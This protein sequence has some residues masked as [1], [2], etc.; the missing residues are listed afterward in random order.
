[1]TPILQPTFGVMVYQEQVMK[2]AQE[3]AG[4]SLGKADLLRRAMGK[5]IKKEMDDQRA[6]FLE[7]AEQKAIDADTAVVIFDQ[8][9]KFAGYGFN[10]SH[11]APY[12]LVT[13]QTAYMKAN[14]PAEFM[15]A[16][17]TYDMLNTDKMYDYCQELKRMGIP[18]LLP[19][20]NKSMP[21]FGVEEDPKTGTLV[22]RYGLAALKNVGVQA[23]EEIV[24]ER[25]HQGP[26][27]DLSDLL[28]RL[29][30]KVLN[31][32]QLE[33]LI[34][35]G[36]LDG[37]YA[38]RATLYESIDQLLKYVTLVQEDKK[39]GQVS[40]FGG[41]QE[42]L[43]P[44]RLKEHMWSNQEALQKEFE[45]FGFYL[46]AHPLQEYQKTLERFNVLP[47][48]KLKDYGGTA[49]Q[50]AGIVS[51]IKKKM[52]RTGKRFAYVTLSD[53]SGSY[54]VMMFEEILVAST[55]LLSSGKPLLLTIGI[56]K[57]D[58]GN[59]RLSCNA[60]KEL[61]Q[62]LDSN[63]EIYMDAST[64][65]QALQTILTPKD[66]GKQKVYV[67]VS[68][69]NQKTVRIVLDKKYDI[70]HV[71]RDALSKIPGVLEVKEI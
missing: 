40:L 37:L 46:S 26:F 54:E 5:K 66:A 20:I 44:L 7:G 9:A 29:P 27:K 60:V 2:I 38:N 69:E 28:S 49:A 62:H 53:H 33:S 56:R 13:Y 23:M 19:D 63:L 8:M 16:T 48:A 64:D 34:S 67:C 1:M 15:A 52:S 47:A 35:T 39:S 41:T 45:A 36:A 30:A 32:R 55:D 61:A 18:L 68:V 3:L 50:M 10:K 11:S 51:D 17:M 24:A 21:K 42:S 71:I 58:E 57:D 12:A 65:V 59:V 25:Q 14:Y 31:K 22:I 6:I 4:Y 43:P 70:T